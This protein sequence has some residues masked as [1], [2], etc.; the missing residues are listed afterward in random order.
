VDQHY[1]YG[2][3]YLEYLKKDCIVKTGE[4]CAFYQ[5]HDWIGPPATQIPQP[6]P[7]SDRPGHFLPVHKCPTLDAEGNP[8]KP[9]DYQPRAKLKDLFKNKEITLSDSD[10]IADFAVK[11]CVQEE[12][13]VE[14]LQHLQNLDILQSIRQRSRNVEK[15]EKL[16]KTYADYDWVALTESGKLGKLVLTEL[17][18]YLK[19][20]GLQVLGNKKDKVKAIMCHTLQQKPDTIIPMESESEDTDESQE[21]VLAVMSDSESSGGLTDSEAEFVLPKTSHHTIWT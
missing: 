2:S 6:V 15:Q 10:K 8:R 7:D 1:N 14:Y 18:K 19:H 4:E 21:V 3:L 16:D 17:N 20:H 11:F 9:D 13:V 5:S 12:Y